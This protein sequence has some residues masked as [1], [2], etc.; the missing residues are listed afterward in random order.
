MSFSFF[1]ARRFFQG[2]KDG[3]RKASTPAIH[4]A[5]AGVA[6]GL[7]VMIISIF[8]V[9]GFQQQVQE[10]ITGF[11]T[12]IEI[13]NDA[14]VGYSNTTPP[15]P[16]AILPPES[17]PIVTDQSVISEIKRIPGVRHVQRTSMKMGIIKTEEHFKSVEMKGIGEEYDTEFL[18]SALTEG[19]MPS[20]SS[21]SPSDKVLISEKI[22]RDLGLKLGDKIYVYFF[23]EV[24]KVKHL[25]ICGIYQT[26]LKQFD[27]V[28]IISD[29]FTVNELNNW[30]ADK[31]SEVEI[32]I[33]DF[34]ELDRYLQ[35]I[36][37]RF[38]GR[39]DTS[40][41]M[42]CVM[43]IKQ[44]PTTASTFQWLN[45]LDF[46]VWAILIIMVLVSVFTMTSGLLILILERIP[47]IG[48][49]K[50]MGATTTSIGHVF[51]NFAALIIIRG[52]IIGNVLGLGLSW[53]Q[54]EFGIVSLDPQSYYVDKVPI[55]FNWWWFI[56]LNFGTLIITLVVLILPSLAI[57]RIQPAKSIRFD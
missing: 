15:Q 17:Y 48:L 20:F 12:H 26:N 2:T 45:L 31:S 50:S 47:T 7:A 56:G 13:L 39:R 52:M 18:K 32:T 36:D 23:E 29:L 55:L 38:D 41:A 14:R 21:K 46:N 25:E 11:G 9:K 8:V 53:L 44:N 37:T 43:S 4:V 51:L 10:K 49:L 22:K 19:K 5:T 27:D 35:D 16:I 28:F 1:L 6:I 30:S 3:K 34:K 42:Y 40:D 57:S 33:S 54:S 24:I